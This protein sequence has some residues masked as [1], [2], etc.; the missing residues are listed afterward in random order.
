MKHKA[1]E[2]NIESPEWQALSH[3][4]K[5]R[6]LFLHQKKTLD[7]FLERVAISR[8]QYDKSLQ[9]LREKMAVAGKKD[10]EY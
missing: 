1:I 4:G 8:E 7:L 3:E 6:V 5:N 2:V 10:T 9:E